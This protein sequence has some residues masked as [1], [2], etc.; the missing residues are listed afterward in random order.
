MVLKQAV[1]AAEMAFAEAAVPDYALGG[2]L[3]VLETAA[4]LLGG[5][6]GGCRM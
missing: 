2:I 1:F 6:A 5:H 3:A 4:N